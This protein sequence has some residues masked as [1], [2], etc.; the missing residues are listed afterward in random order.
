[1]A[2]TIR[3]V[4]MVA[5]LGAVAFLLFYAAR[6]RSA[7]RREPVSPSV[8]ARDQPSDAERAEWETGLGDLSATDPAAFANLIRQITFRTE[9]VLA[10]LGFA[11]G[12]LDGTLDPQTQDAIRRFEQSRQLPVTGDPMSFPTMK[13]IIADDNAMEH[14]PVLLPAYAF[15]DAAWDQGR[16]SARGT[17]RATGEQTSTPEQAT[18]IE[19][20]RQTRRC[21]AATAVLIDTDRGGHALSL[22]TSTY[23]IE[24]WGTQEITTRVDTDRARLR[25][26]RT[27]KSVVE[28]QHEGATRRKLTDG[29][30]GY[31]TQFRDRQRA[32]TSLLALSAD[33]HEWLSRQLP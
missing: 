8:T 24:T 12:P 9:C 18:S 15:A 13:R 30:A 2:L 33:T 14:Q 21:V 10:R 23:E 27:T 4:A 26:S 20:D 5:L 6:S 16:V 31:M 25:L 19:C 29:A 32:Y 3:R 17:W 22:S 1:V 28:E 7:P 11:P